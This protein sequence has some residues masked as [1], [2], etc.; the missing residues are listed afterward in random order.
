MPKRI[1]TRIETVEG[2]QAE[3]TVAREFVCAGRFVGRLDLEEAYV[4]LRG[5][6]EAAGSHRCLVAY[7]LLSYAWGMRTMRGGGR[8]GMGAG[9]HGAARGVG[10]RS[11]EPL[12]GPRA[13]AAA[14]LGRHPASG[15]GSPSLQAARRSRPGPGQATAGRPGRVSLSGAAT[16]G[17]CAGRSA[18]GISAGRPYGTRPPSSWTALVSPT[19]VA[20]P[21]GWRGSGATACNQAVRDSN[22]MVTPVH[23]PSFPNS[24]DVDFY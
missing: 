4:A 6:G 12:Q 15:P 1:F 10:H 11:L 24:P 5:T 7:V 2:E 9:A 19:T 23:S 21:C 20:L 8:S 3:L 13:L 16:T 22:T 18:A 14:R 17:C